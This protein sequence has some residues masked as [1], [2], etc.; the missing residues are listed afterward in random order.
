MKEISDLLAEIRSFPT[1]HTGDRLMALWF[2]ISAAR[3]LTRSSWSFPGMQLNAPLDRPKTQ[4]E[5][6]YEADMQVITEDTQKRAEGGR[7]FIW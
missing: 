1:G 3:E 6:D 2:A 7:S 5:L 4:A